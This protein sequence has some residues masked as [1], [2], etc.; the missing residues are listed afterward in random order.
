[1][2][3]LVKA[4]I[5]KA[6]S[7]ADRD[8]VNRSYRHT[9]RVDPAKV[10]KMATEAMKRVLAKHGHSM[11]EKTI[12]RI[13]TNKAQHFL[14]KTRFEKEYNLKKASSKQE[15]PIIT[16]GGTNVLTVKFLHG[17]YGD[18]SA[19][20]AGLSKFNVMTN[21]MGVIQSLILKAC[22]KEINAELGT[23]LA[24]NS[25]SKSDILGTMGGTQSNLRMGQLHGSQNNPTTIAAVGGAEKIK[26][27]DP[28]AAYEEI[29]NEAILSDVPNANAIYDKVYEK[30]KTAFLA[31]V[32]LENMVDMDINTMQKQIDIEIEF[33][34][35]DKNATMKDYD[36]VQLKK[37][38]NAHTAV[39]NDELFKALSDDQQES[40]RSPRAHA[41]AVAAKHAIVNI[42]GVAHKANPDLRL[43]VNRKLLNESRD[44]KKKDRARFTGNKR[45][46]GSQAIVAAK[47][48]KTR[49]YKKNRGEGKVDGVAGTNPLALKSLL[50]DVLPQ[51][52][53]A[54][55]Q[56]PALRFRTGRFANSAEVTD[57]LVGPRG[58]LQSIDY[59]YQR[60]PYET[61]E[62]GN[63]R[64]S[65]QRDPRK[66]IG[67][68]IR[69]IAI[70]IVGKK[71]IPTRRV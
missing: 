41:R 46:T 37:F 35:M 64:G 5:I 22:V 21:T 54:K 39:I 11:D 63:K 45:V 31:K 10:A 65:V 13:A 61:Y 12:K 51:A 32:D 29:T 50:N 58:G 43:K 27:R 48:I 66:L 18:K 34:P 3:N 9:V 59:T 53:A 56:A 60:D 68:T 47:A 28:N 8:A 62:P 14:E 38:I 40:S 20:G 16:G 70:G 6:I 57:V 2:I 17:G 67:G 49:K 19:S 52:V 7:E 23:S 4:E 1:M 69:E 30:Y 36:A 24:K 26:N 15:D 33:D 55:M 42:L 44:Q 25:A 71:F